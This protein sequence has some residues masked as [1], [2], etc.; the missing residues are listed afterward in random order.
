MRRELKKIFFIRKK[1]STQT[2][3]LAMLLCIVGGF[4]DAYT[5]TTRGKVLANAQTGNL[6]YL[7]L[8][9]AERD[10]QKVFSYFVPIFVF[11]LGILFSEYL[12]HVFTKYENFRWQHTAIFYF[13]HSVKSLKYVS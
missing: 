4:L 7:A 2:F 5:F 9:L 13:I 8:N 3:R 1:D 12:K 6:V 11:A 10:Y